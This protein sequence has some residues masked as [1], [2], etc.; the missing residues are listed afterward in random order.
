MELCATCYGSGDVPLKMLE[1][2][3]RIRVP[4]RLASQEAGSAVAVSSGGRR[5]GF[6]LVCLD[7][8]KRSECLLSFGE[9]EKT[10]K[11]PK[12]ILRIVKI[13]LKDP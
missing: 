6:V 2:Q 4:G 13:S 9:M 11:N 3:C 8:V 10:N 5:K 1:E 12:K 7:G